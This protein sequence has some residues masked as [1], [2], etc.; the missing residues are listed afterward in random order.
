MALSEACTAIQVE[1]PASGN[2]SKGEQ[3]SLSHTPV[4]SSVKESFGKEELLLTA[5]E[6]FPNILLI[7]DPIISFLKAFLKL[8]K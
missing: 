1:P 2:I 5:P 8:N 4:G 6:F 7:D 3:A